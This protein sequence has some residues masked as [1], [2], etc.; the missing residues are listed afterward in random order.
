MIPSLT[1]LDRYR[2]EGTRT[3]SK[4]ADYTEAEDRYNPVI[5]SDSFDLKVLRVP[6]EHLLVYQANPVHQLQSFYLDRDEALFCVHPQVFSACQDDPYLQRLLRYGH[7]APALKVSPSSST[8]TLYV[9][10]SIPHAVKVHFPYRISRYG[11]K[12]RD[13]VIEQAIAVSLEIEKGINFFPHNFAFFREVIGVAVN[14]P[15]PGTERGENWGYLVRDMEPFPSVIGDRK[16]VPGF[17]L[18]GKDVHDPAIPLLLY[19]LIGDEHPVEWVLQRIMLPIVSHWVSCYRIFGFMLEPH[20]QNVLLELD[21]DNQ[22]KRIVHRD[23]SVGIDMR[24]R[25]DCGLSSEHLNEYNRMNS[26]E[27]ASITYDMF[28]GNHFFDRLIACCL[29]RY[30]HLTA[31]DF[32][33]PCC[34]LF[35][36]IFPEHADYIPRHVFYFS[37]K[38]DRYNKPL[39]EQT[40]KM[41]SW[42]P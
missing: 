33:E 27:F 34:H 19:T 41:P 7:M 24:I 31:S 10:A 35:A 26:G 8:R 22:V 5:G 4:H 17:S 28:M 37:E 3:Y 32:M 21:T 18:Y 15:N 38:R 6:R 14:D 1:Y 11:R 13:E 20:G 2:N 39:Y 29:Q 42:R 9:H 25:Q 30:A 40:N 36:K 12:M 23:L 16:L